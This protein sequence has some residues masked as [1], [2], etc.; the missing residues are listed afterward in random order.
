MPHSAMS[1][2]R[3]CAG[4]IPFQ[5]WTVVW[6]SRIRPP[7]LKTWHVETRARVRVTQAERILLHARK[8]MPGR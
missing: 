1:Q 8:S 2:S 5:A 7:F 4:A 3:G 6:R